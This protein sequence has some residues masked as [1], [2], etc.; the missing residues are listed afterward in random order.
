[1]NSNTSSFHNK[2][3][4]NPQ[5]QTGFGKVMP[6]YIMSNESFT[7]GMVPFYGSKL[8]QNMKGTGIINETSDTTPY[9]QKLSDFTGTDESYRHKK[10]T[11]SLFTPSEQ[12]TGFVFGSPLTRPELDRYNT[13]LRNGEIPVEKIQVGKGIGLD[14]DSPGEGGFHQFTRIL[15]ANV[16]DY[17]R[18]QLE[19]RT[20]IGKHVVSHPTSI[21]NVLGSKQTTIYTQE[22][23]PSMPNRHHTTA[24]SGYTT[25]TDNSITRNIQSRENTVPIGIASG[26]NKSSEHFTPEHSRSRRVQSQTLETSIGSAH[27]SKAGPGNREGYYMNMTDRG[28]TNDHVINLSGTTNG[29]RWGPNSFSDS[30]KVTRR[31]TS[32]FA[33]DGSMKG[34]LQDTDRYQ[35][36]G[37]TEYFD[38]NEIPDLKLKPRKG[39]MSSNN[40]RTDSTVFNYTRNPGNNVPNP[41]KG[42]VVGKVDS[43]NLREAPGFKHHGVSRSQSGPIVG[44]TTMKNTRSVYI[45]REQLD[46]SL[47]N[48]LKVNPLS[49][50]SQNNKV[51]TPNFFKP[52]TVV[53]QYDESSPN[54]VWK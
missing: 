20:N 9:R 40:L 26:I 25:I 29:Q 33:R 8:T 53:L 51:P 54:N 23:Y 6:E 7:K 48:N 13:W 22:R 36:N 46:S 3:I 44:K 32:L 15:P 21:P 17:K 12:T 43:K 39:G 16:S 42:I 24:Q 34:Y 18:N 4:T 10:E 14:Y 52:T 49:I 31:E 27:G 30:Q 2:N 35:Y 1:M 11:K 5:N 38:E 41:N 47:Y 50:H 19:N 28:Y 45:E 37:S